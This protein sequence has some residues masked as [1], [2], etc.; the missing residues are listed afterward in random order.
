MNKLKLIS[1][2]EM[3][4]CPHCGVNTPN[5]YMVNDFA[6]SS[7]SGNQRHWKTY[8]CKRCGGV[9]SAASSVPNGE[10]FEIYP[11]E[12]EID[13]SIPDPA[14]SYLSQASSSIHAPAGAIMLAATAVDAMLKSHNYKVACTLVLTLRRVAI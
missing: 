14:R 2:L 13:Q 1:Q 8:V 5:L 7:S 4:Q 6:T 3:D 10:V 12:T 9:I 11:S